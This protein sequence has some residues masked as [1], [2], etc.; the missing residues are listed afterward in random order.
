MSDALK[1]H[2]QAVFNDAA[3]CYDTMNNWMSLGLHH[4]WKDLFVQHICRHVFL[5]EKKRKHWRILDMAAGTGDIAARL[6]SACSAH[7]LKSSFTLADPND[8][9]RQAG[10]KRHANRPWVWINSA[11]EATPFQDDSFNLY[12]IA[13]GLRNTQDK[14]AVFQ[15]AWRVLK[16]GG[17]FYC[18]EF[19]QPMSPV[20]H[21]LFRCVLKTWVPFLGHAVAKKPAAYRY[22]ANS[23]CAFPKASIIQAMM[24]NC[25]FEKTN[26]QLL[27]GGIVALH[28]GIKT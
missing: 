11:A 3:P 8:A 20:M 22:L 7:Q 6:N 13:F 21:G 14:R 26:Y 5:K 28:W 10:Q 9:M 4:V 15:E 12:T 18:L 24:N 1:R 2:V 23:I 25:S 19:S 17:F 16:K 27:N